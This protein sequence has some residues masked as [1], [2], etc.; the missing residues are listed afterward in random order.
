MGILRAGDKAH[1]FGYAY[2]ENGWLLIEFNG[3]TGWVSG[4]YARVVES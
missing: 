3:A 2:P 1:Y 4:K